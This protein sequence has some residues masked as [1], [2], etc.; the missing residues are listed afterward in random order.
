M[1]NFFTLQ[2][3]QR[4]FVEFLGSFALSLVV[5]ISIINGMPGIMVALFAAL[6][7][8]IFVY[9]VGRIS[10]G[11]FNPAITAGALIIDGICWRD[12]LG[13][14][15]AQFLGAGATLLFMLAYL[16]EPGLGEVFAQLGSAPESTL[17]LGIAEALGMFFFSFGVAAVIYGKVKKGTRGFVVGASL[18]LGVLIAIMLGSAGILNPML[19][20]VVNSFDVMYI[21]GPL[22]GSIL[23][24]L[25]YSLVIKDFSKS[26]EEGE[27]EEK[28]DEK[29]GE[30]VVEI[31]EI[32]SG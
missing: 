28:L 14:I 26:K 21:L 6:T 23:G 12:T 1:I 11:H 5:L 19:A 18:F 27:E 22:V 32:I 16:P 10:G 30:E 7:L 13:Y 20:L 4:Y 29:K 9:T 25:A 31:F 24:M 3:L 2:R 17:S 15:I 8:C